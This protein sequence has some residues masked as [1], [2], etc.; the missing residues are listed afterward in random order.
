MQR[1][2]TPPGYRLFGRQSRFDDRATTCA[3]IAGGTRPEENDIG[4]E[5]VRA[6]RHDQCAGAPGGEAIVIGGFRRS[7]YTA[8]R[9][10]GAGPIVYPPGI[11]GPWRDGPDA[12][13][14]SDDSVALHGVLAAG[15]RTGSVCAMDGTSVAAPQ[16]TRLIAGLMTAGLASDRTAVQAIA[17][18]RGPGA[19]VAAATR[20]RRTHR[21]ATAQ[22]EALEALALNG[23][24]MTTAAA[25]GAAGAA[26]YQ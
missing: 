11:V 22:S 23:G 18:A 1:G 3:S 24:A 5:P 7:D 13:A 2:D 20:R 17:K 9:Y 19:A 12:T 21:D 16:I 15:T 14:V 4:P 10:S 25:A 6:A 26:R 8:S